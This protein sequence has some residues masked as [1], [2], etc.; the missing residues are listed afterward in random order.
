VG[1]DR[2]TMGEVCRRRPRAGEGTRTGKTGWE[3]RVG[4]GRLHN[5]ASQG[6]AALGTPRLAPRRP[7]RRAQRQRP[8]PPRRA[9]STSEVPPEDWRTIPVP[10]LV[11]PEVCAAGQTQLQ[12]HKPHARPA[13]RGAWD[14]LHGLRQ[15]QPCGSACDGKRLRPSARPGPPRAY[16]SDRGLGTEAY[17]CGGE[18]RCPHT[19]GRT[20]RWDLAVWQAGCP[21]FTPPERLAAASRRRLQPETRAKRPPLATIEDQSSQ[22]RQGVARLIDREAESRIDQSAFAPRLPRLRLRLARREE[23]RQAL[24]E[25]AAWPG[26]W[27]R[28]IG[29]L[30]DCAARLHA[31]W[32]TADWASQRDRIRALGT[33]VE[34]ARNEG[35]GV[36]RID[37]YPSDN[38]PE[39]KRLPLCRGRDDSSLWCPAVRLMVLPV[40]HVSCLEKGGD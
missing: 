10:A 26:E 39:K 9:G 27:Q 19:Q 37:P 8:G 22:G 17:R 5:P 33:R 3:R 14:L 2:L 16:A 11:A 12:E 4:W 20:D 13:R 24:A 25:E 30:E 15:C 31:G 35:N 29:R 1:R 18:R 34:V 32:E 28:M 23:Q 40:L 6:A 38:D 36:F 7:R 21:W